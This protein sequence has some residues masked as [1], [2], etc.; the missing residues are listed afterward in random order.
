[1][2]STPL[3][4][5]LHQHYD[6]YRNTQW[7]PI[8]VDRVVEDITLASIKGKN[9][10]TYNQNT[11]PKDTVAQLELLGLS[12]LLFSEQSTTVYFKPTQRN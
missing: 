8:E 1:M 12:V 2:S 6:S 10:V 5:T 3:L 4:D 11:F 9:S 7:S